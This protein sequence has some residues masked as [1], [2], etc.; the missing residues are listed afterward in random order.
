[1]NAKNILAICV[2]CGILAG[3]G[4]KY[5]LSQA[6]Q[7]LA[8]PDCIHASA[9]G[10][11][12]I[13]TQRDLLHSDAL[14]NLLHKV[15]LTSLGI[16][17]RLTDIDTMPD[18]RLLLAE[19]GE[20]TIY[21]CRFRPSGCEPFIHP[22]LT[23]KERKWVHSTRIV[24]DAK[25]KRILLANAWLHRIIAYDFQGKELGQLDI[26]GDKQG[27]RYP[28]DMFLDKDILLI[29]DANHRRIVG[30][31]LTRN[32]LERGA[33]FRVEDYPIA[34]ASAGKR[35]WVLEKTGDQLHTSIGLYTATGQKTTRIDSAED[36]VAMS[37]HPSG[38]LLVALRNAGGV[39]ATSQDD[40]ALE[41]FEGTGLL[42]YFSKLREN[43]QDI[44][45]KDRWL[46]GWFGLCLVMLLVVLFLEYGPGADRAKKPHPHAAAES[47]DAPMM[48][49]PPVLWL[50]HA[51]IPRWQQIGAIVTMGLVAMFLGGFLLLGY[52][53]GARLHLAT[54]VFLLLEVL[55]MLAIIAHAT[56]FCD[57]GISGGHAV[58]LRDA[59]GNTVQ[60]P[61]ESLLYTNRVLFHGK[62][63]VPYKTAQGDW[64]FQ[65]EMFREH[66]K[67]LLSRATKV[68]R[69]EYARYAMETRSPYFLRTRASIFITSLAVPLT[70][71]IMMALS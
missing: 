35:W 51:A 27:L 4:V 30:F 28:N 47:A 59:Y 53:G 17:G 63:T 38:L 15:S 60:V 68:G 54:F 69:K 66:L 18:G 45:R 71:A 1:M 19:A 13:A 12:W 24:V 55:F 70:F 50:R 36:P 14:G 25:R 31:S 16:H 64:L 21:R 41:P 32:Q 2:V 6:R 62:V 58:V 20:G 61:A 40:L 23:E 67:P 29:A 10:D 46:W 44:E 37:P 57:L 9:H 3:V 34:V 52:G 22:K 11:V 5:T 26:A 48:D 43:I 56:M 65:R 42:E 49:T 8:Y 7:S 33:T 39:V